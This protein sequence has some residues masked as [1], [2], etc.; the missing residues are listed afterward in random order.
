MLAA[1][2]SAIHLYYD[3]D[4]ITLPILQSKESTTEQ[5]SKKQSPVHV[6]RD[7]IPSMGRSIGLRA[8]CMSVF[9]P[10]I[11]T[12]FIRSK[13]WSWSLY[14]AALFWDIP[15]SRLSYTP[16]YL[17][18]IVRSYVSS[19]LLITLWEVSNVI[20]S[21]HVAQEPLKK[22]QPLTSESKDPN[23][24]LL[25]GLKTSREVPRVC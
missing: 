22:G 21:L 4:K 18:V 11:Y 2:Q 23:G 24:S 10:V 17:S 8:A 16:P 7:L 1:W 9:G 12:G 6:L 20:F 14:F 3:Y 15:N 13:A 5:P 25:I 19:T